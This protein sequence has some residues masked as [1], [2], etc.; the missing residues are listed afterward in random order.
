MRHEVTLTEKA[1][2]IACN[3]LLSH[4]NQNK[5]QEELCFALWYP[6]NGKSKTTALISEIILPEEGE[7]G[8]HGNAS[9]S[10]QFLARSLR[11]AKKKASLKESVGD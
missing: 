4:F 6:C 10:P 8:L 9:F 11:I 3:H 2:S 5:H 7:R 1:H